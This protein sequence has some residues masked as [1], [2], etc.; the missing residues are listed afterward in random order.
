MEWIDIGYFRVGRHQFHQL[1]VARL[2]YV[3]FLPMSL[4]KTEAIYFGGISNGKR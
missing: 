1:M 4:E 3:H 2:F